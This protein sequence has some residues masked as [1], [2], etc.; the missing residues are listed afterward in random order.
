MNALQHNEIS[1]DAFLAKDKLMENA[2]GPMFSDRP[3]FTGGTI[4]RA[5]LKPRPAGS[6]IKVLA[7]TGSSRLLSAPG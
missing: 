2:Q 4:G 7:A 6:G 3:G 5:L 1:A